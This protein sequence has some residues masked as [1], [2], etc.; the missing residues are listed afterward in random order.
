MRY[1]FFDIECANCFNGHGKICSFGYVIA[2]D[3]FEILEQKDILINPKTKFHLKNR[4]KEGE[5]IELSYPLEMFTAS[6]DFEYY[7]PTIKNLLTYPDQIVF[8]HSVINDIHFILSECKRY[9]KP[10]FGYDAY[11]TQVLYKLL[12]KEKNESSLSKLCE[13]Y[14]IEVTDLHRSDYDAY[15]TMSVMKAL[16]SEYD[17]DVQGIFAKLP[18]AFYT[19]KDDGTIVN[20][21]SVESNSKKLLDMARKIKIDRQIPKNQLIKEKYFCLSKEF[22]DNHFCKAKYLVRE[23]RRRGG[24]YCTKV[25]KSDYFLKGDEEC[26]RS[27]NVKKILSQ[28]GCRLQVLD[29]GQ[30]LRMLEIDAKDYEAIIDEE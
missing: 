15:L 25:G 13:K 24:F 11:D 2:D 28:E 26:D 27:K 23:I 20:N 9:Y 18:T 17:T 12:H 16:C 6:P 22:E 19:V 5:D 8:G 10:T 21:F 1:L 30:L 29:I 14:G 3:N 4:R 7:Y